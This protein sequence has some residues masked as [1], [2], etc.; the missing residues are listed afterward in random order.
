MTNLW[1]RFTHRI[2]LGCPGRAPMEVSLSTIAMLFRT[3]LSIET[4]SSSS[5]V[6][7]EVLK[8]FRNPD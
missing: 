3:L 8:I 5:V 2:C 1:L 7:I 6:D 4:S